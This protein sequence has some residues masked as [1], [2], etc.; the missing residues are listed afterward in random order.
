MHRG[1]DHDEIED[2]EFGDHEEEKIM[3]DIREMRMVQMKNNY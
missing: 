1:H 3:R 2:E